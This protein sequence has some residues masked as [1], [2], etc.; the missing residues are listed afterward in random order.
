M[1]GVFSM[2]ISLYFTALCMI[3]QRNEASATKPVS[4]GWLFV[5]S[6][7]ALRLSLTSQAL[8]GKSFM[9]AGTILEKAS[10][11][12]MKTGSPKVEKLRMSEALHVLSTV[13]DH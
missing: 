8:P 9:A 4:T 5:G 12:Y 13:G 3:P 1:D 6:V 7:A 11:T 2:G 10:D